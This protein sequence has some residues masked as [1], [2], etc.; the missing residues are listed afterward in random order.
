MSTIMG[1][2][3]AAVSRSPVLPATSLVLARGSWKPAV[4]AFRPCAGVKCR[5]PLTVTCAL[6]EKERPPAFS[7]PPTALLCPVPPPDGK[8]RWDIKEEE[9]RV[10]L[11][12]QVPGLSVSDIE[13][14]T[15]EDVLEIKRKV[16]AQQPAAAVD[17]H[18]VGAFHIRLLMTKEY[19]GTRVTA[20]LKAG[21]LEVTVPKNPQRGSERVE[22]GKPVPRGKE[23][24]NTKKASE[25]TKPDQ[26]PGKQR[27]GGLAG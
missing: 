10:T 13:V 8:E 14:T 23:G 20:D 6:P 21:M 11:W 3:T 12:L 19:D 15:G 1:S 2:Y 18:G 24:T 25:E 27:T 16:T 9:D 5:R 26:T 4:A 17:A 7:I 22:L